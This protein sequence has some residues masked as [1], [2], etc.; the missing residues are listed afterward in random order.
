MRNTALLA[1]ALA[2]AALAGTSPAHAFSYDTCLGERLKWSSNTV[3]LNASATSFPAGEWRTTLQSAVDRFNMNPSNFRYQLAIDGGSVRRGNGQSEVWGSTDPDVLDGAP[4]IAYTWHT[5]Y[6]FFGNHVHMDEVDIA[7]DYGSPWR[8]SSSE[9]KS[10]LRRY[11]GT[12][13]PMRTTAIHEM[14]HGLKLNH[15]NSEYNVMGID[16]EHIHANGSLARAYLGEDAADGAVFL[17]GLRSPRLEDVGVVHWKYSGA[18]GEYSDHEKTRLLDAGGAA[19]SAFD[20]AGE[21]RFRV[22][23][24]QRVQAEFT[25]ENNGASQQDNVQVGFFVSTNDLITTADRRIAGTSLNLGRGNVFTHRVTVTIPNDLVSGQRYW[26]GVIVD[27]GGRISEA[28]EWNNA[29]YLPI[30]VQ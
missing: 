8:W 13:R 23:R 20:D 22:N 11:G 25:Y 6:W 18:S 4:A 28:A 3:T 10:G 2:G 12:L 24:G 27:E 1:A 19:L 15:V 7:F 26:L 17:Y 9:S 21:T 29:T 30:W 14:G 16:F 5:C